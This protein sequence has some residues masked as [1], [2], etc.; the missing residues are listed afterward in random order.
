MELTSGEEENWKQLATNSHRCFRRCFLARCRTPTEGWVVGAGIR[1][2]AARLTFGAGH[3][4]RCGCGTRRKVSAAG[5]R[6]NH[7]G[8]STS[9]LGLGREGRGAGVLRVASS[10]RHRLLHHQQGLR[11]IITSLSCFSFLPHSLEA[12]L[13]HWGQCLASV[14]SRLGHRDHSWNSRYKHERREFSSL[15]I[16]FQKFSRKEYL[17]CSSGSAARA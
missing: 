14:T 10:A 8:S 15:Q 17:V 16:L 7:W 6:R 11:L 3:G 9:R 12:K 1:Q 2:C 5:R 4:I 13:L